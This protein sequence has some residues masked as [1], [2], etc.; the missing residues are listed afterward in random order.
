MRDI[1]RE[2]E[3]RRGEAERKRKAAELQRKATPSRPP[4]DSAA[5]A[6]VLDAVESYANCHICAHYLA[7]VYILPCGHSACAVCYRR[8]F[9]TQLRKKL[10]LLKPSVHHRH[11]QDECQFIPKTDFQFTRLL[12]CFELHRVDPKTILVYECFECRAKTSA[13][14]V[15][16]Y[17]LRRLVDGLAAALEGRYKPA[18]LDYDLPE[19]APFKGLFLVPDE[20]VA[21]GSSRGDAGRGASNASQ[22]SS[23]RRASSARQAS[24]AGGSNGRQ[25]SSSGS[26]GG[27]TSRR[28]TRA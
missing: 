8:A 23:P 13:A 27:S 22:A 17:A 9:E 19:N 10:I 12:E 21:E 18:I 2:H 28:S 7:R 24:R 11:S 3:I 14:P 16:N 26:S 5:L 15:P 1:L 4:T 25:T 6:K 20:D